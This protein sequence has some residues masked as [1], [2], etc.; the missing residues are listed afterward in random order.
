[1]HLEFGSVLPKAGPYMKMKSERA[2]LT[3]V[4]STVRYPLLLVDSEGRIEAVS[5]AAADL[6]TVPSGSV[7]GRSVSE[8]AGSHGLLLHDT[9]ASVV[10]SG[11]SLTTELRSQSRKFDIVVE[12][13][14]TETGKVPGATIHAN[15]RITPPSEEA[16]MP[17]GGDLL[18]LI[19]DQM[20]HAVCWKDRHSRY[21]GGNRVFAEAVG[22]GSSDAVSGITDRDIMGPADAEAVRREDEQVLRTGESL[23]AIEQSLKLAVGGRIIEKLT[24]PLRSNSGEIMGILCI[25]RDI[26]EQKR[27]EERLLRDKGDP[28]GS[29]ASPDKP[30]RQGRIG[31]KSDQLI[32]LGGRESQGEAAGGR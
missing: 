28:S 15:E 25:A 9:V 23:V 13:L 12:P 19:L 17:A 11:Q 18:R 3:A 30:P 8:V 24:M 10:A 22:L 29:G 32:V 21:L 7:R 5:H 26:T 31:R 6:L 16:G 1:M 2:I 27:A 20:P 4:L 14:I